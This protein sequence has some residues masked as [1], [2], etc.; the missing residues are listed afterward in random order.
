MYTPEL[1]T[2][3]LIQQHLADNPAFVELTETAMKNGNEA[4]SEVLP[5]T[6]VM[7]PV[8]AGQEP[9][10]Y[11]KRCLQEY[12]SQHKR[13]KTQPFAVTLSLNYPHTADNSQLKRKQENLE[14]VQE[15]QDS[16]QGRGLPLSYFEI[17]YAPDTTI[18]AIRRHLAGASLGHMLQRYA[19]RDIPES[20]NVFISDIDTYKYSP[21]CFGKLQ[22]TLDEGYSM[23]AACKQYL[24]TDGQLPQIDRALR[25]LNLTIRTNPL[26][27]YDCH[28]MYSVRALLAGDSFSEEDSIFETHEMR[29]RAESTMGKEFESPMPRQVAGAL[30]FSYPRR[31]IEQISKGKLGHEFWVPDEFTMQDEYRQR[32]PGA[33]GADVPKRQANRFIGDEIAVLRGRARD[34][35]VNMLE[36]ENGDMPYAARR[37]AVDGHLA[38]ILRH[39]NHMLELDLESVSILDGIDT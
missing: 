29:K 27:S 34:N 19:G 21:E 7:T 10:Q 14:V 6:E 32:A 35:L 22:V 16:R 36:V 12:A 24:T 3:E 33:L 39:S 23:A 31:P 9:P 37:S 5:K 13:D 1:S 17:A 20:A 18:G 11:T 2:K 28:V 26:A 15:F 8:A 4:Y 25:A 30:A 38:R